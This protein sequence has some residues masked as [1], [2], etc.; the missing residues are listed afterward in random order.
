MW[1]MVLIAMLAGLGF[2]A[3]WL[4]RRTPGA[5]PAAIA[6]LAYAPYEWLMHARVLCSGECNIRVDLLLIWPLLLWATLAVPG[7]WLL[8]RLRAQRQG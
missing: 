5:G 8:R 3:C 7:R 6:W 4:L 1:M 2:A